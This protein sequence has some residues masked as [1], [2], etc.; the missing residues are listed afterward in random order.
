MVVKEVETARIE[1]NNLREE[2]KRLSAVESRLSSR[3]KLL[4]FL[5][6]LK[7]LAEARKQF[8]SKVHK[9]CAV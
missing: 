4:K 8:M 1:V 2:V 6:K 5:S 3:W 7:E 9:C